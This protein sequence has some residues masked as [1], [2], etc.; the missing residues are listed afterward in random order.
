MHARVD[1]NYIY[2]T[3]SFYCEYTDLR[4]EYAFAILMCKCNVEEKFNIY[5]PSTITPLVH[6][7]NAFEFV[8]VSAISVSINH[9]R[10]DP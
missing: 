3:M 4:G 10:N 2:T 7:V 9:G 6:F 1:C 5:V 8:T